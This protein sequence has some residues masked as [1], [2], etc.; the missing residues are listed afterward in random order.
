MKH[1]TEL[2]RGTVSAESAGEGKGSTFKVTL[3]VTVTAG[4]LPAQPP[5]IAGLPLRTE[6]AWTD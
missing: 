4:M 3:P 1:L 5:D 2:H 6:L